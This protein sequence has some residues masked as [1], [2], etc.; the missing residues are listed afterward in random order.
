M[1]LDSPLPLSAPVEIGTRI[2]GWTLTKSIGRGG[3]GVVYK[4][5]N[6]AGEV[7]AVK[8]IRLDKVPPAELDGIY[9]EIK[10]LQCLNHPH[11]VKYVDASKELNHLNIILEYCEMG[12]LSSLLMKGSGGESVKIT[13]GSGSPNSGQNANSMQGFPEAQTQSY[14]MQTLL[15]LQYLHQQGV[16]HRDIKG[17]NILLTKDGVIKLADFG[18][19]TRL[20]TSKN[21]VRVV[22][23]FILSFDVAVVGLRLFGAPPTATRII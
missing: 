1:N 3:F 16:I 5:E 9:S 13:G 20:N 23:W 6:S 18:V 19:A 10:L 21:Q 4:A 12:S 17:A 14:T 11:I 2:D 7:S 15:G 8:R 22:R